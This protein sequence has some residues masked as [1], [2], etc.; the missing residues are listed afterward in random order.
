MLADKLIETDTPDPKS[1]DSWTSS[2][3]VTE[4]FY[5][6]DTGYGVWVCSPVRS[7]GRKVLKDKYYTMTG[8]AP[9]IAI[10][11]SCKTI[12]EETTHDVYG[13][14]YKIKQIIIDRPHNR[15]EEQIFLK[16]LV[17]D[18]QYGE[19]VKI[20]D[21]PVT[22]IM[23]GTFDVS[24]VKYIG[25]KSLKIITE[26][27]KD[28]I[29]MLSI[30]AEIGKY[31]LDF[32]E[33]K[34]IAK[35]FRSAELAL[36]KIKKNPYVLYHEVNGFGFT[37][38]DNI[39]QQ[40]G[41]LNDDPRRQEAAILYSLEQEE[42]GGNT[43]GYKADIKDKAE[44]LIGVSIKNMDE[45]IKSP[46]FFTDGLRLARKYIW[47]CEHDIAVE[48]K[49]LTDGQCSLFTDEEIN[50]KISEVESEKNIQYDIKQ[51]Q[52]FYEINNNNVAILCGFPGT[53]KSSVLD[54]VLDL[55]DSKRI[56]YKLM[57]PTARAAK[58]MEEATGRDASTIHR[59][60]GCGEDGF[61]HNKKCPLIEQVYIIDEVSML[62]IYLFRSVLYALPTGS[63][64]LCVGDY[65]Q[66]ESI[67]AGNVL[68]DMINSEKIPCVKLDKVYRQEDGSKL[69]DV[70]TDIR[71]GTMFF[72][73]NQKVLELG[74]DCKLWFGEKEMTA[75]RVELLYKSCLAKYDREDILVISPIK[76]G[77]S[78][79]KEL[80]TRLQ[81]VA[82]PYSELKDEVTLLKCTFRV[83]DIV[84]HTK[85]NY[86]APVLTKD[87]DKTGFMGVFN[88]DVGKVVEIN[89]D[90]RF[91]LFVD[92]QGRIIE[93]KF[94]DLNNLELA[95]CLTVHKC[96]G[97]QSRV[98]IM[99]MDM[100]HYMNL[101]R[102]LAYT[103]VSRASEMLF[104]V[105]DPKAL[106]L[107]IEND[108]TT[109]KRTFL[110]EEINKLFNIQQITNIKFTNHQ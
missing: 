99:A 27:V 63:K 70:I 105:A 57:S 89:R 16:N 52:I 54:G 79:V 22:V 65:A 49:R 55:F 10:G 108:K 43:Y 67:N 93:Y 88:G 72:N 2:K 83:G 1:D 68:Y 103:G 61:A 41:M 100:S 82:N 104:I 86:L 37:K 26:K 56:T 30:S 46:L 24:K 50:N 8:N 62:D 92:Y 11:G 5:N 106:K 77:S 48:L 75:S 4:V 91:A 84:M 18:R 107:A 33:I 14:Q 110:M 7:D 69:L 66:L 94:V 35:H 21:K 36:Q 58:R 38:A 28:N 15:D 31:G 19:I 45:Y 95:Y 71:E 51:K 74:K 29:D 78:G 53:G 25:E 6:E 98:V 40:M 87:H 9:R 39:A 3:I 85:N 81:N 44:S 102:S 32:K 101:K 42:S 59:G 76:N 73:V 109:E 80:N 12:L 34:R 60:L 96:Q 64:L 17:T 20:Y 13:L 23:N 90:G 47:E 97:A